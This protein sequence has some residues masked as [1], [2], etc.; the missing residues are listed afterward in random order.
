M[1]PE[2]VVLLHGLAR[3]SNSMKS[4][5]KFFSEQGYEVFNIDYPSRKY[6][7]AELAN[8]VRKE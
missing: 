5:E 2:Y 1:A 3:T 8:I 4:L 6:P 7:V